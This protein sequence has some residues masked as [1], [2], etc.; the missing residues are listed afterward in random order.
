[1]GRT[2]NDWAYHSFTLLMEGIALRLWG[3]WSSSLTRWA[4]RTG[5]SSALGCWCER[6]E[7]ERRRRRTEKELA[8]SEEGSLTGILAEEDHLLEGD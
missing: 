2:S 8:C 1:M 7:R 3:S 6:N 4:R 5:S